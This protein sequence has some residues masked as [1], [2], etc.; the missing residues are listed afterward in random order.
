MEFR[1]LCQSRYSVR[2]YLDKVVEREKLNIIVDNM[3]LA[4]S[5]KNDQNWKFIIV[6]DKN[7]ILKL[8]SCIPQSFAIKSAAMILVLIPNKVQLMDCGYDRH[9]VN[10]SIATTILHYSAFDLGL[11]SV[12]I[13]KFNQVQAK[14][15]M[16]INDDWNILSI[17]LLGYP[18][19][20]QEVI[21]KKELVDIVSYN[22]FDK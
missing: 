14:N 6:D 20:S 13:G 15:V 21:K 18:E 17:S 9:V 10:G 7:L 22:Q 3:R 16:G 12:W 8:A 19:K 5:A 4:F 2:N 11:G 1:E